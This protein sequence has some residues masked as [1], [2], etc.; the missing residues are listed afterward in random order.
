MSS[1]RALDTASHAGA[2]EHK[3]ATLA[4]LRDLGF[5]VPDDSSGA[6]MINALGRSPASSSGTPGTAASS[7]LGCLSE[8]P[9]E[10]RRAT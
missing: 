3:A 8:Q 10:A 4:L 2:C 7:C 1:L 6:A 9:V 5:G